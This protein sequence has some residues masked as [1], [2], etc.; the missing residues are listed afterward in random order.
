MSLSTTFVKFIP[1]YS[2]VKVFWFQGSCL[3]FR[4]ELPENVAW[5]TLMEGT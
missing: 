4:L 2:F 1:D 3:H 5:K